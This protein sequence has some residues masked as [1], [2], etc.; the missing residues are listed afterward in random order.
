[1]WTE[2]TQDRGSLGKISTRP[3]L[4]LSSSIS[5]ACLLSR[6]SARPSSYFLSSKQMARR[7]AAKSAIT[8][9]ANNLSN[10][11]QMHHPHLIEARLSQNNQSNSTCF[12]SMSCLAK[13]RVMFGYLDLIQCGLQPFEACENTIFRHNVNMNGLR[14]ICRRFTEWMLMLQQKVGGTIY[15]LLFHRFSVFLDG[16]YHGGIHYVFVFALVPINSWKEFMEYRFAF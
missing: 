12:E 2:T 8:R 1:M 16:W 6:A 3:V 13:T 11:S 10:H 7:G 9:S 4:F 5:S 14:D 15:E